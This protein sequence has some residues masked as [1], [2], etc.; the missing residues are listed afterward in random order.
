LRTSPESGPPISI[1][2][3]VAKVVIELN[4]PFSNID[5]PNTCKFEIRNNFLNQTIEIHK[6]KNVFLKRTRNKENL[7]NFTCN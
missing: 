6:R 2:I 5:I 1:D 4:N 7:L 3:P